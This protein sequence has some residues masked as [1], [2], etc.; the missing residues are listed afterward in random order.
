LLFLKPS[1]SYGSLIYNYLYNM[2]SVPITSKVVSS[3][4][5]QLRCTRCY[6]I[7]IQTEF[8]LKYFLTWNMKKINNL[9][10]LSTRNFGTIRWKKLLIF[11]VLKHLIFVLCEN[12]CS[13]GKKSYTP[14]N[15]KLLVLYMYFK[16]VKNPYIT[17]VYIFTSKIANSNQPLF[18]FGLPKIKWKSLQLIY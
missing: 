12:F 7:N 17:S 16:K 18:F 3:N 6:T 13:T 1:W 9:H 2:Q 10:Y 4:S 14:F 8:F 5:F 11:Q 15:I